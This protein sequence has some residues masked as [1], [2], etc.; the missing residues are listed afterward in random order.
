MNLRDFYEQEGYLIARTVFDSFRIEQLAADASRIKV[1]YANLIDTN[2]RRCRWQDNVLTGECQFDAFDPILDLSELVKQLAYD[3]QL[4]ELLAEI[5][6]EPACLFKDKLIFKE[7]GAKGYA[8]HQDWIAWERFPPSFLSVVIPLDR[9][10]ESN[11]CTVVYPG[12]HRQGP[13]TSKDGAYH[14]LPAETV[15]EA[16]AIPLELE[17]GDIAIFSGFTP[18]RSQANLSQDSRRQIYLS[19]TKHSEGGELRE[20]HYQDFQEWLVRKYTEHGRTQTY[21]A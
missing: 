8:L 12:Y 9:T 19:Y 11:G 21:F 13:L 2:N 4:K 15:D 16:N 18:H 7:P 5:Y 17:L 14:E 20:Q 3:P 1:D 6:G 10:D